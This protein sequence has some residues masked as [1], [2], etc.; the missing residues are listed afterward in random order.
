MPSWRVEHCVGD[1]GG[2]HARE[3]P[4]DQRVATFF[5]VE[6]PVLVLGSSQRADS[7]DSAWAAS[8][9]IEIVRRRSGG[10]GVLLWP[11]E[12]VWL[13]VEIPLGDPLWDDDIA[14]SMWWIGELWRDAIAELDPAATV[15]HGRLAQ[16]RWSTDV[17]F[18]GAGPGEVLVGDAKLVGISQRR[19][20]LATRFQT[21]VHLRWRP[22]IVASLVVDHPSANELEHLVRVCTA[23]S[24][25]ISARLTASLRNL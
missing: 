11:G 1:A 21:M 15:Y 3:L 17:C 6:T 4:S 13:D 19:T 22:D 20:R 23:S 8:H 2:F 24:G 10:G 16:T 9:G 25:D 7:V 14:R 12:F 18:A 5:A